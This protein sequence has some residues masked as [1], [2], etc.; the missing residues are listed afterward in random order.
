[1]KINIAEQAYLTKVPRTLADEIKKHLTVENPVY[2]DNEKMKRW[3]GDTPK[4]LTLYSVPTPGELIVPRGIVRQLAAM[5]TKHDVPFEWVDNTRELPEVD[6]EFSGQ[7]RDYQQ[8]AVNKIHERRFSTLEAPTGSG[9]TIIAMA[10][11]AERKQPTL[12]ITHTSTLCAQWV[13]R[14]HAFL[15]IPVEQIGVIGGGKK[16]IGKQIT[17]SMVQSL[18]K[19]ADEVSKHI[20]F[21]I[22]DECHRTPSRTFT[23]AISAFDSKFQLGLSATAF[24]RDNLTELIS[25]YIGETAHKI[26]QKELTKS[27]AILP[28]KVKWVKTQFETWRDASEE[29]SQTLS[30]LTKDADRNRLVA[31]EAAGQAKNGGGIPLILSDRKAHC[32]TIAETMDHDHGIKPLILTGDLSKKARESVVQRLNAGKC[33]A[34][35]ATTALV[36]EGF[37]MPSLGSVI[38][39]SPMKFKGRVIQSIGRGLRPSPGQKHAVVVD[40]VDAN[41]GV[42]KASA[43]NRM[44]TYKSMGGTWS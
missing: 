5:A 4:H 16:K 43:R 6:F 8:T 12:I 14:I 36:G 27:G 23:E 25:W 7:L 40:F 15:G 42:L 28:F 31:S 21:L 32:R 44:K 10:T 39:A 3:Q 11:I 34:L 41:I 1:M 2:R 38:L 22:V 13:D 33:E 17:V 35:V 37:D 9:K 24:R 19:I 20:G 26:D 30:D 29:Y 18:Y